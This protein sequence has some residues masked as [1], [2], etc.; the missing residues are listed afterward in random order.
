MT[1]PGIEVTDPLPL[2]A[3]LR[4]SA[5]QLAELDS[6]DPGRQ[7]LSQPGR[8]WPENRLPRLAILMTGESEDDETIVGI[9]VAK[10][11]AAIKAGH[12]V[13]LTEYTHINPG[14]KPYGNR[15]DPGSDWLGALVPSVGLVGPLEPQSVES[16][17]AFLATVGGD[18]LAT[19]LRSLLDR[20][21]WYE[22]DSDRGHRWR[23]ERDAL[24]LFCKIAGMEKAI[25]AR[26]ERSSSSLT[27][28]DGLPGVSS[29]A[30]L[31]R[32][33]EDY[34]VRASDAT[35]STR[36]LQGTDRSASSQLAVCSLRSTTGAAAACSELDAVYYHEKSETLIVLPYL[37]QD[38]RGFVSLGS[39]RSALRLASRLRTLDQA[40]CAQAHEDL[41]FLPTASFIH[42]V[43][44]GPFIA[45][46]SEPLKGSI[47]PFAHVEPAIAEA[48]RRGELRFTLGAQS[49]HLT[50]TTLWWMVRD[51]WI[52]ARPVPRDEVKNQVRRSL[53][54]AGA[55]L[56]AVDLADRQRGNGD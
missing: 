15:A 9:G 1:M 32:V 2:V 40:Y 27:Y 53:E 10:Q 14:L 17:L 4:L 7:R 24:L 22:D 44:N 13:W 33:I 54:S 47:F 11:G 3:L 56:L 19:E 45:H 18:K 42:V 35:A 28:V 6:T 23:D 34:E 21:A 50:H 51:G 39:G 38:P 36:L 30:R 29:G 37:R 8:Q 41:R 46:T 55:V 12:L 52:G 5:N 49:R 16:A 48:A 25:T 20:V 43:E 31:T 26:W